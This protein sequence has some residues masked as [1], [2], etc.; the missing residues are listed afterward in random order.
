[1]ESVGRIWRGCLENWANEKLTW[2]AVGKRVVQK[3]AHDD[4]VVH[5]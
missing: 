5:C 2:L 4:T 1:M 3:G